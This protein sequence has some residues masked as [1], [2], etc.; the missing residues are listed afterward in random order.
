MPTTQIQSAPVSTF[1]Q[2]V[3]ERRKGLDLTQAELAELVGCS[4]I[5][6]AKIESGERR[7]SK[8]IAE[9]MAQHLRVPEEHRDAFVDFARG[10]TEVPPL[11]GATQAARPAAFAGIPAAALTG[12]L[13]GR[14]RELGQIAEW[15]KAGD[16]RLITL[17]GPG[18]VGKTQLAL[19][20]AH[21]AREHFG[22]GVC[23]VD[24][25]SSTDA[26]SLARAMARAMR[27][28][29]TDGEGLLTA[30][31]RHIAGLNLLL[32]LDNLEQVAGAGDVVA[33]VIAGCPRVWVLATSREALR[34]G[35]ERVLPVQPLGVPITVRGEGAST[36]DLAGIPSVAL[37][38][39]RARAADPAFQL[40]SSNARA[41]AELCQRLDGLPLAL[42]LAAARVGLMTPQALLAKLAPAQRVNIELIAGGATGA[43]TRQRTLRNTIQ[44]SYDLLGPV[45]QAAFRQLAVFV[46]GCTLEAAE[47]VLL[48]ADS[49]DGAVDAANPWDALTVQLNRSLLQRREGA[50]GAVRFVQLETLREFA[51][52]QL[53]AAPDAQGVRRRHAAYFA[54]LAESAAALLPGRR[55]QEGLAQLDADYANL[56]AAL[57]WLLQHDPPLAQR[58]AVHLSLYWDVRGAFHEG[59]AI[60]EACLAGNPEPSLDRA[61]VLL[62]L[63]MLD[64]TASQLDTTIAR[65]DEALMLFHRFRDK[66]GIAQALLV[67]AWATEGKHNV[68]LAKDRFEQ[69]LA[70]ARESGDEHILARGHM[71]FARLLREQEGNLDAASALLENALAI[72][73]NIG[74]VR[75]VAHA[76]MQ[77]SEV[78]AARGDY[79]AAVRLAGE[80]VIS[81]RELGAANELG[82]ALMSL[83]ESQLNAGLLAEAQPNI[84]ASLATL[85]QVGVTWGM[86][87]NLH[88][89]GRIAL[90]KCQLDAARAFYLRSMALCQKLNRPHMTAR[91]LAGLAGV[92]IQEGDFERAAK[93]LGAALPHVP[94]DLTPADVREYE[95]FRHAARSALGDE[96]YQAVATSADIAAAVQ[97]AQ[98]AA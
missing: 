38:V 63:A 55:L 91:C 6:I 53:D 72:Y 33:E 73:R 69:S 13:I 47:A 41:V 39:E 64:F 17:V 98:T 43:P 67:M 10:Q 61:W 37:F 79:T 56:R 20:A 95:G 9:L 22:Q 65:C 4:L 54:G 8:Q 40:T 48:V 35:D 32:L 29:E 3:K 50:D 85:E 62:S 84:E 80:S 18:G 30:V 49:A 23:F 87:I 60:Y 26:T 45:E 83:G 89:L 58:M 36:A 86:A 46:G 75:G 76:L 92:A 31:V 78:A 24:A 2:W 16:A 93:L 82:W 70:A 44:W 81:F 34:L 66:R 1:A 21:A 96:A 12:R 7:P 27:A 19:R 28:S 68:A 97:W 74:D 88:H 71:T 5:T 15:L 90:L 51:A 77:R 14:E 94:G 42:E 25:A 59:R 11:L 52:Q 57:S